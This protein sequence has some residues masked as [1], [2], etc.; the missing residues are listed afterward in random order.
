LILFLAGAAIITAGGLFCGLVSERHRAYF[1]GASVFA[2]GLASLVPAL[3]VLFSGKPASVLIFN[4]N[5]SMDCLSAFFAVIITVMGFLSVIYS[6]SYMK[7]YYGKGRGITSHYMFL[8]VLISSMMLVTVSRDAISFMISWEIM[9]LS[10]FF[11]VVF[12]NEKKEVV[13][14]GI[15]YFI[16]S[17]ISAAL[18]ISGFAAASNGG[19][20]LSFDSI[21]A[22]LKTTPASFA[23]PFIL[24]FSGFALKAGIV[25]LHTWL[26]R[27]HPAAPSH[28]S[29]LMSGVMIKMG[30]Y[31]MARTIM[32]MPPLPAAAGYTVLFFGILTA[33][34]GILYTLTQRDIKR[35]LAYSSVENMGIITAGFG[36][37]ILGMAYKLPYMALLGFLGAFLH[38]LNHSIFKELLFFGAGTIYSRT[39]TRDIEHLG[40]LSKKMPVLSVCFLIGSAAIAG[41]PP[42]NG[43]I[44]EF[45]LY[46]SML[47]AAQ[48][49]IIGLAAAGIAA[50][51]GLA[52]TGAMALICFT[53]LYSGAFLGSPRNKKAEIEKGEGRLDT[54]VFVILAAL[55]F[56]LGLFPQVIY[57]LPL[58]PAFNMLPGA[59]FSTAVNIPLIK[60][61]MSLSAMFLVLCGFTAAALAV[62]S[63]MLKNRIRQGATWGC[64]Y[65]AP[66]A[67]MQYSAYSYSEPFT[68]IMDPFVIKNKNEVK[69]EGIF[70]ERS[71]Y[72]PEFT[73]VFEKF[74]IKPAANSAQR[75][76]KLFTWIQNGSMQRYILYAIIF[77][78]I[79]LVWAVK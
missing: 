68:R 53:R 43:F 40:G 19:T 1:A 30:I 14:A 18:L 52:F 69:P 3:M 17:H 20:N 79:S 4:I 31:G 8:M 62:K 22:A 60:Q 24:L 37:G 51:A 70:P 67:R 10:S 38:I 5:F 48:S 11:L 42:L 16:F 57:Y 75:L 56:F 64:A 63:V 50:L 12:E 29:G 61:L 13:E 7:S 77:L 33:L 21:G 55:C 35:I 32:L 47:Q 49:N 28:V 34:T 39:H 25:P 66:T 27:A 9:A 44:S 41:L 76:L 15:Y 23:A 72:K 45:I 2:G 26:P 71:S 6:A 73:D 58:M 59:D 46:M 65:S 54:T 36:V 78:I 74:I